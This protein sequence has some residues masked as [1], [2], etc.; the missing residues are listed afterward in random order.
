MTQNLD[1][2]ADLLFKMIEDRYGDRLSD[3]QLEKVRKE[4]DSVLES[5]QTLRATKLDNGVPPTTGFLPGSD[6]G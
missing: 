2:E 4:L 3:E 5:A 6:D 1:N